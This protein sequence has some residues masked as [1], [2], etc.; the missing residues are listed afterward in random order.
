MR[1]ETPK[2]RLILSLAAPDDAD[3]HRTDGAVEL[4]HF[5]GQREVVAVITIEGTVAGPGAVMNDNGVALRT[6][7]KVR[8]V[9]GCRRQEG[10]GRGMRNRRS[11]D[12]GLAQRVLIL[13]GKENKQDDKELMTVFMPRIR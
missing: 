1:L 8:H 6:I 12:G 13:S 3:S 2:A 4:R 10:E 7:G 5:A 11:A 9:S